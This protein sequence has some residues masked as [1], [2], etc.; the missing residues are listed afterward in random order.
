M[1]RRTAATGI[2]KTTAE[3]RRQI[4]R[5]HARDELDDLESDEE[6]GGE[7]GE[8]EDDDFDLPSPPLY[9]EDEDEDVEALNDP[10]ATMLP[11]PPMV[12]GRGRSTLFGQPTE[13]VGVPSSPP[14]YAAA[15]RFPDARKFVVYRLDGSSGNPISIGSIAVNC[16]EDGFIRHFYKSMPR[17]GEGAVTYLLRMHNAAGK[18]VGPQIERVI[19]DTHTTLVQLREEEK[20]AMS[21]GPA[22]WGGLHVGDNG[23]GVQVVTEELGRVVES[24]QL[25]H[26]QQL[27]N[28]SEQLKEER[29]RNLDNERRLANE[30]IELAKQSGT[31]QQS[32]LERMVATDRQRADEV[33]K[34][35]QD[36]SKFVLNLLTTMNAQTRE[37]MIVDAQRREA[38]EKVRQERERAYFDR[39]M[40]EERDRRASE[41]Q[42]QEAKWQREREEARAEAQRRE[43]EMKA[44]I[45]LAKL[46]LENRR[47]E[48]DE[49]AT[50]REREFELRMKLEREERDAR[51]RREREDR[52]ARD[53]REREEREAAARLERER[54]E[55]ERD[56][57]RSR[58][59]R[60]RQAEETRRE[61]E[62]QEEREREERRREERDRE[63][64]RRTE[65]MHMRM[66][67]LEDERAR[68]AQ[69]AERDALAAREHAQQLANI[70]AQER[71]SLRLSEERRLAAERE[72]RERRER[73]EREDREQR[74]RDRQR[75]FDLE[76]ARLA[77]EAEQQREHQ[78]S[79]LEMTRMQQGGGLE[80][81]GDVFKTMGM[82]PTEGLKKMFSG[83]E[84]I[85]ESV[86]K[87]VG[88]LA[89]AYIRSQQ[90]RGA[91][92]AAPTPVRTVTIQTPE[93]P[94]VI[95]EEAFRSM[96]AQMR[97][98]PAA[99][100]P[101]IA[102]PLP[103][104]SMPAPRNAP[105]VPATGGPI[106]VLPPENKPA[107]APTPTPAALDEASGAD[108][109]AEEVEPAIPPEYIVG[110]SVNVLVRSRASGLPTSKARSARK[111]VREL[112]GR[113]AEVPESDWDAIVQASV[114][115]APELLDYLNA[116]TVWAALADGGASPELATRIVA[117]L[118]E[119][120]AALRADL[121]RVEPFL[122]FTEADLEAA[123][124]REAQAKA[125]PASGEVAP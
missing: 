38:E 99:S 122:I 77:R 118:V 83:D 63:E 51:E 6:E 34:T 70:A 101:Q 40:R 12:G 85:G 97:Q 125:A 88:A 90:G 47:K 71:E 62:R 56:E 95:T 76:Q 5:A 58:R 15:A 8:D 48:A 114:G 98:V 116:V 106:P 108:A 110:Q 86:M 66:K 91:G 16:H 31:L 67:Q 11:E 29:D 52:D 26:E 73:A 54:F 13:T 32:I 80:R 78:R 68:E 102:G 43:S 1:G 74:E 46:E 65:E 121:G 30:R 103:G 107:V 82:D 9:D 93:G 109:G 119:V 33:L 94:R 89:E 41:V 57:E 112:V 4:E 19:A 75:A 53:R 59:E 20:N 37:S 96:Q 10:S 92:G 27:N 28:L 17:P 7:P 36:S 123:R 24:V 50:R 100:M 117:R 64:K 3:Q 81:L 84:G 2:T 87:G 45:E 21:A 44:Q 39:L 23:A 55:R 111:R 113:L 22:G 18:E 69:R 25:M 72:D 49:A 79:L 14:L 35:Q 42:A 105:G 115:T 104:M 61:R 60:E 120:D 124:E